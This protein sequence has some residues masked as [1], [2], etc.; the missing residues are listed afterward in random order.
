MIWE[1]SIPDIPIDGGELG[2]ELLGGKLLGGEFEGEEN[3]DL[4]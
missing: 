2:G 1:S 4:S 3:F